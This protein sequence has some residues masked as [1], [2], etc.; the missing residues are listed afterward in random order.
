M[1]SGRNI[2]CDLKLRESTDPKSE[3]A[4][5]PNSVPATVAFFD[6]ARN[7]ILSAL[8][9]ASIASIASIE[10]VEKGTVISEVPSIS[11]HI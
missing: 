1:H 6:G 7:Q 9:K 8:D 4:D 3:S 2:A 5:L 11:W 10:L